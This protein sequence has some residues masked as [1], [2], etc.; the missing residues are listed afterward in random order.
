MGRCARKNSFQRSLLTVARVVPVVNEPARRHE[1]R[2]AHGEEVDSEI[3]RLPSRSSSS[4]SPPRR[5]YGRSVHRQEKETAHGDAGVT[6]GKAA[7]S[8]VLVR[9]GSGAFESFEGEL[10]EG[11]EV[12]AE[13][14]DVPEGERREKGEGKGKGGNKEEA[15]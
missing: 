1:N 8:V 13:A 9:V 4:P 12:G 5:R 3:D 10:A 11:V 15:K 7:A 2:Q 6:G 14:A